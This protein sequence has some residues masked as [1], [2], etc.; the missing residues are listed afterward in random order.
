[1][2]HYEVSMPVL[3]NGGDDQLGSAVEGK[4]V[5]EKR[6]KTKEKKTFVPV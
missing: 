6:K 2:A 4:F 3:N 1:M 5:L